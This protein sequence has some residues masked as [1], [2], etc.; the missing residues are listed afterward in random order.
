[1]GKKLNL[2]VVRSVFDRSDTTAEGSAK[3][4]QPSKKDTKP[5]LETAR[6]RLGGRASDAR[7][8]A[9]AGMMPGQIV[10]V[11]TKSGDAHVGVVLFAGVEAIH[12]LLQDGVRLKRVRAEDVGPYD[13]SMPT[14]LDS[15]ATD[16]RVFRMMYEGQSIRYPDDRGSL[17]GGKLIEKCR[18]GALVAREDGAVV[19]VGFRKL[20]PLAI[21]ET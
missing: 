11:T 19:A 4:G 10:T 9:P 20:W 17:V 14:E 5:T 6:K 16:A 1:M 13:G 21:A 7:E 8:P 3:S 15:I 12:V 18:Y 2:P